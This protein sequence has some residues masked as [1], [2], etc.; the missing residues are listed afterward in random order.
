MSVCI[1]RNRALLA[2]LD[3]DRYDVADHVVAAVG[4]ALHWLGT[5]ALVRCA[6]EQFVLA[7]VRSFPSVLPASPAE[8]LGFVQQSRGGPGR[9]AVGADF[10]FLHFRFAGPRGP[11]DAICSPR[12]KNLAGGGSGNRR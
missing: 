7:G 11:V 10:D 9:A 12:G 8:W 3:F 2:R 6:G 1:Y 5:V 4:V